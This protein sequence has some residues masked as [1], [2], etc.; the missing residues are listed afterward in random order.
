MKK[1]NDKLDKI[2]NLYL[3]YKEAKKDPRKRA[4]MKL[5]GYFIFFLIIVLIANIGNEFNTTNTNMNTTTTTTKVV[6]S[7]V[8]KQNDLITSKYNID[9]EITFNDKIYKIKG[10]LENNII[11]GYLEID[12][13]IKKITIK[14]NTMYELKHDEEIILENLFEVNKLNLSTIINTIKKTSAFIKENDEVKT[15]LYELDNKK[16]YVEC[17][18]EHIINIKIDESNNTYNMNFDK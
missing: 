5:L 7:Y 6:D 2:K 3:K 15:Y 14:N 4:G 13:E 17:N 18:N 16:I 1:N 10:N 11:N 12:N 8:E 9:Y